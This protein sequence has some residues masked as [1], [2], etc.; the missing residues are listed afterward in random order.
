MTWLRLL[1]YAASALV[2]AYLAW[3]TAD[4]WHAGELSALKLK[5]AGEVTK[6]REGERETCEQNKAT[7]REVANELRKRLQNADSRYALEL[8]RVLKHETAKRVQPSR[9]PGGDDGAADQDGFLRADPE[10]AM[11]LLALG[12]DGE[13]Q[14][15]QL[16]ACQGFIRKVWKQ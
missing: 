15:E 9:T 4:A 12:R 8:H 1:P 16:N 7:S 11:E 14:A 3:Q 10:A 6:A 2:G 5:H 13:R